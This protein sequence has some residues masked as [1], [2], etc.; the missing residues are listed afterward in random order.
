MPPPIVKFINILACSILSA[1]RSVTVSEPFS[2]ESTIKDDWPI[3]FFAR[4][5]IICYILVEGIP[6]KV[7]RLQNRREVK[8][9]REVR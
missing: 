1:R 8:N 3:R 2:C 4:R 7:Y 6:L 5:A 9:W